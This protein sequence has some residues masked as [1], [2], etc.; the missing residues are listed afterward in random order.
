[1]LLAIYGLRSSEV[2]KLKLDDIDWVENKLRIAR[3]KRRE[4]QVFPLVASVGN[5]I[6]RY[7]KTVRRPSSHREIFQ[8]LIS[9]YV[10]LSQG[11][12]YNVV[13]AKIKVLHT[14]CAHHGP[15]V[16]RHA[17]AQRLVAEGLSL[18]EIGDHL[19]HSSYCA[20]RVYAKVNLAGLRE[21]AA[22][23]LGELS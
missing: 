3:A 18:K 21:I 11:G 20:T 15:H 13:S 1:M 22:F 9:P 17:C 10:P 5:A 7:I 19:G 23:D 16:L 2:T 4:P 6:I 8:T 12:L 14:N